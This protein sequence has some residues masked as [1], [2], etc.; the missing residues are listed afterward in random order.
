MS[1]IKNK[2]GV[3]AHHDEEWDHMADQVRAIQKKS[4]QI[5]ED[6]EDPNNK[7]TKEELIE[8]IKQAKIVTKNFKKIG[9][10][11][12]RIDAGNDKVSQGQA[13]IRAKAAEFEAKW[14]FSPFS[15]N[16]ER[17]FAGLPRLP[18]D[19]NGNIF[20]DHKDMRPIHTE[21]LEGFPSI[22]CFRAGNKNK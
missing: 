12:D 20:V 15:T 18:E 3:M 7:V 6:L 21:E 10:C 8:A 1:F 14:G 2:Q 5:L 9:G 11:L 16:L 17:A 22:E 19:P 4:L 13:N